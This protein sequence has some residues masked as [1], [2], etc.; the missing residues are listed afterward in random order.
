MSNTAQADACVALAHTLA[1]AAAKITLPYFRT[2]LTI[3][4]KSDDSPVTRADRETEAALRK[5]INETFPDHGII[6]EEYGTENED[7]EFVWVLDPIDGTVSFINGV[8]LFTTIVGVLKDS[9]P[10]FGVV[11]QPVLKDRWA[12]GAGNPTTLNGQPAKVRSCESLERA[13]VYITAP[14]FFSPDELA[15]VDGLTDA[16]KLRRFG[17]TDCYHYG[18]VASGWTD[19]AC[20]KLSVYEFGAMVPV[21][22]N[23]GGVMTDWQGNRLTGTEERQVLASGDHRVHEA[24]VDILKQESA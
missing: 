4:D 20:E 8:P 1:D 11:D 14:D 9:V 7:A 23:A 24:A 10:W 22:E 13:S 16:V 6:G 3:E 12:G 5:L 15:R 17:G 19:M 21:I 2:A 18:M